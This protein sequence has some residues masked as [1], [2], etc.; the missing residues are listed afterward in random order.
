MNLTLPKTLA[1]WI[2]SVISLFT[3]LVVAVL[4]LAPRKP[5]GGQ[6]DVSLLPLT[7]AAL[8]GS[9][10]VC[11]TLGYYFIRRKQ[12]KRH[13]AM[14]LTAFGL[15]TLFL[16]SYVVLHAVAGSTPF[17]GQGWIRPA[18]FVILISHIVLSAVVLP[19]SL[20]TLYHGWFASFV[21]HRRIARWTFP[22]WLYTS[23]SGVGVYLLLYH[24]PV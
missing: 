17:P 1:G 14:M 2:I 7:N 21:R 12:I 4:L 23:V 15:S 19:L 24:W 5:S 9:V 11:L 16:V 3:L 6:L 18:Y 8:N 13:R 10:A 20:T 22:I